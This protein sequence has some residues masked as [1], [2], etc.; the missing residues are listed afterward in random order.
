MEGIEERWD[1]EDVMNML[2]EKS[3]Q[4]NFNHA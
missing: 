1:S 2:L 3:A 4:F